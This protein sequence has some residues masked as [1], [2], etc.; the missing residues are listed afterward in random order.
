MCMF[1]YSLVD[2]FELG[3]IAGPGCVYVHGSRIFLTV[4]R[5]DDQCR[6][7]SSGLFS[8]YVQINQTED[9][10]RFGSLLVR[11]VRH[12]SGSC[13]ATLRHLGRLDVR[14][15]FSRIYCHNVICLRRNDC[16]IETSH[17]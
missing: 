1:A 13:D 17:G 6:S 8:R 15:L 3:A 10:R 4:D 14:C 16:Q 7:I 11:A 5:N 12:H 2:V 9:D